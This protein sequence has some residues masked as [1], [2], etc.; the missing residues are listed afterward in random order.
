MTKF[1]EIP[2]KYLKLLELIIWN[3]PSSPSGSTTHIPKL[4]P[5]KS[6]QNTPVLVLHY[7]PNPDKSGYLLHYNFKST[8]LRLFNNIAVAIKTDEEKIGKGEPSEIL[9]SGSE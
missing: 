3:S 5:S 1:Q 9:I 2:L 8:N 7:C 4:S 6:S